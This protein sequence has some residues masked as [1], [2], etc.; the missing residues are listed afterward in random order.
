MIGLHRSSH[1]HHRTS[2]QE[3]QPQLAH[4]GAHARHAHAHGRCLLL[5]SSLGQHA[6]LQVPQLHHHHALGL[7][8]GGDQ[9]GLNEV[10]AAALHL[11]QQGAGRLST[12]SMRSGCTGCGSRSRHISR[13]FTGLVVHADCWWHASLP[14]GDLWGSTAGCPAHL[15]EQDA[16]H[17]QWLGGG[18]MVLHLHH[19]PLLSAV[20]WKIE[21]LVPLGIAAAVCGGDGRR[22]R[23]VYRQGYVNN[24]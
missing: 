13:R 2:S 1:A 24:K 15:V 11:Q 8:L 12:H 23:K 7:V 9:R 3:Q 22:F 4:P 5:P 14:S 17:A 6:R 20:E 10:L 18:L 16:G 19:Q 21:D